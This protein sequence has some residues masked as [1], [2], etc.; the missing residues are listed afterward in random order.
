MVGVFT[1]L[2]QSMSLG[3]RNSKSDLHLYNCSG[4][5]QSI[6]SDGGEFEFQELKQHTVHAWLHPIVVC[7]ID[8]NVDRMAVANGWSTNKPTQ[9]LT[10][11]M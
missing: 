5:A 3:P 2:V 1:L 10:G 9:M 6:V 4:R 7:N 11:E 8:N